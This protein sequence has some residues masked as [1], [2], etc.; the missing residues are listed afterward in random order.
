MLH[1]QIV[2]EMETEVITLLMMFYELPRLF[3]GLAVQAQKARRQITDRKTYFNKDRFQVELVEP[4]PR[5]AK[6]NSGRDAPVEASGR[7]C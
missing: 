6:P 3:M 1:P 2:S 5:R 4:R 7:H